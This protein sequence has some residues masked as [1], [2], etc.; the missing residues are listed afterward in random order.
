[1]VDSTQAFLSLVSY[2]FNWKKIICMYKLS[3]LSV[4]IIIIF[5]FK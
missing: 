5:F 2:P 3:V 1:M 4:I